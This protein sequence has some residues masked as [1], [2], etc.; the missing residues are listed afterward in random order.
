MAAKRKEFYLQLI[1]GRTGMAIDDDTGQ[2]TVLKSGTPDA[3]TVY[4][5]ADGTSLMLPAA[6]TDGVIR[7]FVDDSVAKVDLSILTA[8]GHAV[9]MQDVMPSEH[10]LVI[11]PEKREYVMVIPMLIGDDFE[12][13]T[14]FDLPAN[15]GILD[16]FVKITTAEAGKKINAGLLS[17]ETGGNTAGFL[18]EISA[19]SVGYVYPAGVVNDGVN[20]DY[21]NNV[22]YGV[23]LASFL[24]GADAVATCGG[25]IRKMYRTDGT[26]KSVVYQ[27][28]QGA[29]DIKGYLFLQY[30][31]LI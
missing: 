30:L 16:A 26:A 19:A 25:Q 9:F 12:F 10:R 15:L 20:V 1:N 27:G 17:T 29:T 28:V 22:R 18:S 31:R 13:D 8:K 6:M 7:F 3:E 4:A 5:D 2:Y 21:V 14:G 24:N 23:F 11:D